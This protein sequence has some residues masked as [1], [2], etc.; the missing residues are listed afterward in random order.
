MPFCVYRTIVW[1][2]QYYYNKTIIYEQRVIIVINL[3]NYNYGCV[4][5]IYD[6]STKPCNKIVYEVI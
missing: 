2:T 6:M 1:R 5:I 4:H 3:S